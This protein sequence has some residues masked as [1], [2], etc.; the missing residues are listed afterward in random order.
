LSNT[1]GFAINAARMAQLWKSR[2][3]SDYS[4]VALLVGFVG[5]C[6]AIGGTAWLAWSH[7]RA[8]AWVNHTLEVENRLSAVLS[9]VVDAETGQRGFLLT[10]LG[11]YLEPYDAA[12]AGV[13]GELAELANAIDDNP[14]QRDR[15]ARL[16][17]LADERD[18]LLRETISLYRGGDTASAIDL[19]KSGRG[20]T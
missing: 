8:V 15:M 5:L 17:V 1:G 13:D 10:G 11:E 16:R 4:L 18:N 6:A 12:I 19:V 9:R 20:K 14:H 3:R 2:L 7:Q